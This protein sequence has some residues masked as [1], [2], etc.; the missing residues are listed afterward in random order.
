MSLTP[1]VLD[2][3]LLVDDGEYAILDNYDEQDL[4]NDVRRSLEQL[5]NARCRCGVYDDAFR[6]LK[7][8][9]YEYGIPDFTEGG[10]GGPRELANFC[11]S[12]ASAIT[13]C[14]PR[15]FRVQVTPLEESIRERVFR[16]QVHARLHVKPRP[17]EVVYTTGMELAT[18]AFEVNNG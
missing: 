4:E 14:E 10:F 2:R 17:R 3:L 5:F 11:R 18:Y 13:R 12:V 1:S 7:R 9:L 15:L 16:F 8:S 6:E